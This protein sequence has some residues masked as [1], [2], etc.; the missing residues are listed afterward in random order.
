MTRPTIELVLDWPLQPVFQSKRLVNNLGSLEVSFRPIRD[1]E[2]EVVA[3]VVVN[4]VGN[5]VLGVPS[6]HIAKGL[7]VHL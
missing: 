3:L 7:S 4:V 1:S 2:V 5:V 6:Y